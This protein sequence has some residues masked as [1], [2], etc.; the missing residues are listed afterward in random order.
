MQRDSI[1]VTFKLLVHN[2][3]SG[4][5]SSDQSYSDQAIELMV[6]QFEETLSNCCSAARAQASLAQI[7]VTQIKNR[8]ILGSSHQ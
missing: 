8:L 2:K 1:A 3:G 6:E 4:E 5:A 7:K